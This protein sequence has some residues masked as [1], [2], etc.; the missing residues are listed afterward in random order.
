MFTFSHMNPR[1]A[2]SRITA[3]AGIALLLFAGMNCHTSKQLPATRPYTGTAALSYWVSAT[4]AAGGNGSQAQPFQTLEQARDAVRR[5][6][7]KSGASGPVVIYVGSGTYRLTKTF[8]L[9]SNDGGSPGSPVIYTAIAGQASPLICGSDSVTGWVASE[10]PGV[11][12]APAKKQLDSR[13]FYVNGKRAIRARSNDTEHYPAGFRPLYPD[14][15]QTA[16]KGGIEYSPSWLNPAG[17][18][19]PLKWT[20]VRDIEAVCIGQWKIM[21]VPLDTIYPNEV[22]SRLVKNMKVR[23]IGMQD[24]AWQN[25]NCFVYASDSV[26]PGLWSFWRVS[27]FEN[28]LQFV[29][30]PGEY[31]YDKHAGYVYYMP[32]K[33]DQMSTAVGEIPVLEKLVDISGTAQQPVTDLRF[34]GLTFSYATWSEPSSGQGYVADQSGFHLKGMNNERNVIGHVKQQERTPGNISVSYAHRVHFYGN[35]FVHLGGVALDFVKGCRRDS[36]SRNFFADISSAAVQMG[37]VNIGDAHPSDTAQLVKYNGIRN[38]TITC[39]G[40][41]Y[42][43]AAGIMLGMTSYTDVSHNDISCTPWSGIAI[44]WGWGLYDPF[45]PQA[46]DTTSFPGVDGAEEGMW[47]IYKSPSAN[48]H[49]RIA[50]NRISDFVTAVWDGGAV[51]STGYQGSSLESGLVLEGNVAYDKFPRGGSNIFYTDGG[52][53]Y[54][55]V[56]GNA[57]YNNKQGKIY[58]GPTPSVFDTLNLPII[59]YMLANLFP[60]GSEIGG[61]V[62]CGDLRYENNYWENHWT[63]GSLLLNPMV[64]ALVSDTAFTHWPKNPLYYDPC[65]GKGIPSSHP[66]HISLQG[67]KIIRTRCAIPKPILQK[68][69]VEK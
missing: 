44:G 48:H 41:D 26:S 25:A 51:Y 66:L 49:N 43:D 15:G 54:V 57:L 22:N 68:A 42:L 38:N 39:I 37:G 5:T 8:R 4:A 69:G 36:V 46:G 9:D 2:M 58:L 18:R 59:P 52:S 56:K 64:S 40:R 16:D 63:E 33:G 31:Y 24:T 55:T 20:H 29:D 1:R 62:T 34:E 12:K 23:V 47:G 45:V 19:D 27:R 53:R 60:Y 61:C 13:Q 65:R 35:R 7:A 50:Y 21:Y 67:N 14:S 10:I 6:R 11:W 3:A 28:A 32:R 17:W 30:E